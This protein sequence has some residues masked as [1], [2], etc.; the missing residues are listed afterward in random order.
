MGRKKSDRELK[1][2]LQQS[3][4]QGTELEKI[5]NGNGIM[6]EETIKLCTEILWEQKLAQK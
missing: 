2:Y 1:E 6:L 3:M 4:Q 5:F